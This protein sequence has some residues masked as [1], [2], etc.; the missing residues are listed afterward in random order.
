MNKNCSGQAKKL[1]AEEE[2]S[3]KKEDYADRRRKKARA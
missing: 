1:E 3:I 2:K